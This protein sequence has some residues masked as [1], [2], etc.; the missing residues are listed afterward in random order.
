MRRKPLAARDEKRQQKQDLE[1]RQ[2]PPTSSVKTPSTSRNTRHPEMRRWSLEPRF[3]TPCGEQVAWLS[4]GSSVG[5][6]TG[7]GAAGRPQV[8]GQGRTVPQP[9]PEP[10]AVAS[11]APAQSPSRPGAV[12]PHTPHPVRCPQCGRLS[13]GSFNECHYPGSPKAH[14]SPES[15]PLPPTTV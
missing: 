13:L 11:P 15:L 7:E 4:V 8:T 5:T 2:G 9:G 1:R 10:S 6:G 14:F 3:R 12:S